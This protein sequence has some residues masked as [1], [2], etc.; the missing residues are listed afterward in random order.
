MKPHI[1]NADLLS[2]LYVIIRLKNNP[3]AAGE[4][5]TFDV[6]LMKYMTEDLNK[7]IFGL[8]DP[9]LANKHRS[10][11]LTARD[12]ADIIVKLIQSSQEEQDGLDEIVTA[13][14][15]DL[16]MDL[17]LKENQ[18]VNK[19]TGIPDTL[20]S[21]RNQNWIPK[22]I[23]HL[24]SGSCFIAVGAGHLKYKT[25]VIQLLRDKGYTLRPVKLKK[26]KS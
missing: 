20:L 16:K 21:V 17:K 12:I 25:G 4:D 7:K 15:S 9:D 24:Q 26:L 11:L 6:W 2:M 5:M 23:N 8:D 3:A 14:I 22:I 10:N 1:K 18:E 19:T 13:Y